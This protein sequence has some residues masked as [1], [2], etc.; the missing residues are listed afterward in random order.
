MEDEIHIING[1]LAVDDRGEIVFVNDF[2]F[3]SVKRFYM[4]SNHK[5]GFVRAWHAHKHEAKYVFVVT[6]A[7]LVGAV[8]IDDWEKPSVDLPVGRY[9]LS[10][11]KP[12]ILYIP[13]GHANGFMSLTSDL[14]LIFYSTATLEESADDDIRF[15][16]KYWDIWNISER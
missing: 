10:S 15:D 5:Q 13:P 11:K 3:E 4:V 9:V 14:K 7:A 16:A 1:G 12:Q 6:G 8:K 2:H